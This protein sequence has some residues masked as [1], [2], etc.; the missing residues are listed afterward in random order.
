[1]ALL[2]AIALGIAAWAAAVRKPTL[3]LAW[4]ALAA[5]V[6]Q[7]ILGGYRVRMNSTRLAMI[8]GCTAQAFFALMVAIAVVT[9]RR[10]REPGPTIDDPSHLRRRAA[11]TLFLIVAQIGLGAWLRHEGQSEAAVAHAVM[12]GA[13]WGH[14][15]ALGLRVLRHRDATPALVPS[16]RAML[17]LATLQMAVGGLAWWLL[18]PFDGIARSV[19][20]A[21]AMV[22]IAHQGLGALLLAAAIVLTLRA[23]RTLRSPAAQALP[24]PAAPNFTTREAVA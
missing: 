18:R 1:M 5:V 11:W 21:Q 6:A 22:R 7:G 16:A 3:A 24:H 23:F 20:P 4:L 9:G 19:W 17:A 15:M 8:H 13:V 2:G 12:A 10:W 14:V